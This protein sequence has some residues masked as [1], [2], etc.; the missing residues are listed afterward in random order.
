MEKLGVKKNNTNLLKTN[1]ASAL[2]DIY[3]IQIT[4]NLDVDQT[5]K[6]K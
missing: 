5:V 4:D 1:Y 3:F 6:M 2:T